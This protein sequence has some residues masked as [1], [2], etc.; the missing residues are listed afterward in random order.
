MLSRFP[1]ESLNS[2]KGEPE[3]ETNSTVAKQTGRL[4]ISVIDKSVKF[5]P[6]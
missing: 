6:L 3:D 2:L 1:D 5:S 4:H